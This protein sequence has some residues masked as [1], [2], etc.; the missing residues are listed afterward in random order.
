MADAR[1]LLGDWR[2]V[3]DNIGDYELADIL[4]FSPPVLEMM[5]PEERAVLEG[6]PPVVTVYRGADR[7]VN[8]A[9]VRAARSL[10]CAEYGKTP[11]LY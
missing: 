1:R 11:N 3:C 5:T 7:G 2:S 9:A 4:L 8:D 6:L 10:V